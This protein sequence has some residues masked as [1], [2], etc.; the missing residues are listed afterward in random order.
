MLN[1]VLVLTIVLFT[2]C[3]VD[4]W[5]IVFTLKVFSNLAKCQNVKQIKVNIFAAKDMQYVW[6]DKLCVLYGHPLYV[7]AK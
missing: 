2:K 1:P 4:A 6:E 3:K 7:H 5:A